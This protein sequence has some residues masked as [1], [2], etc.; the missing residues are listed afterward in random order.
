[1]AGTM[2]LLN[3]VNL[4][5]PLKPVFGSDRRFETQATHYPICK[6]G[7]LV[8]PHYG[9]SPKNS[10]FTWEHS[11]QITRSIHCM[12]APPPWGNPGFATTIGSNFTSAFCSV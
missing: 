11:F 1:M 2:T 9:L 4:I 8:F 10:P 7:E 12:L 6:T 3:L 5:F